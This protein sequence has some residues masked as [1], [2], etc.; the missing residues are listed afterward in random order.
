MPDV[1]SVGRRGCVRAAPRPVPVIG[2]HAAVYAVA[3]RHRAGNLRGPAGL[4]PA[5]RL[6]RASTRDRPSQPSILLVPPIL[7]V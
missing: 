3:P 6:P 5:R 7:P 1:Q 4:V 2:D